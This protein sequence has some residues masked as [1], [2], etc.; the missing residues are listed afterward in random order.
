MATPSTMPGTADVERLTRELADL[1]R[2]AE[3]APQGGGDG[4]ADGGDAFAARMRAALPALL[5]VCLQGRGEGGRREE[6]WREGRAEEAAWPQ[7]GTRRARCGRRPTHSSSLLFSPGVGDR[8]VGVAIRLVDLALKYYPHAVAGAP[9]ARRAGAA[10]AARLLALAASPAAAAPGAADAVAAAAADLVCLAVDRDEAGFGGLVAGVGAAAAGAGRSLAAAAR[11]GRPPPLPL[12]ADATAPDAPLVLICDGVPA[13]ARLAAVALRVVAAAAR[14]APAAARRALPRDAPEVAGRL[15]A[16]AS[17]ALASTGDADASLLAAAAADA[18]RAL[19]AAAPDADPPPP[20]LADGSLAA[21]ACGD[22][23]VV[24]AGARLLADLVARGGA[25]AAAA[26]ARAA[27][28]LPAA[29]LAAPSASPARAAVLAAMAAVAPWAPA[30]PADAAALAPLDAGAAG[31]AALAAVLSAAAPDAVALDAVLDAGS[32]PTSKKRR[33]ASFDGAPASERAGGAPLAPLAALFAALPPTAPSPLS[34]DD[35]L[36]ALAVLARGVGGAAPGARAALGRAA[37]AHAAA[38]VGGDAAPAAPHPSY[39]TLALTVAAVDAVLAACLHIAPPPGRPPVP[40]SPAAA[41]ARDG[42]RALGLPR[43][44]LRALCAAPWTHLDAAAPPPAALEAAAKGAALRV[45]AVASLLDAGGDRG[46]PL[47]RG[48]A[49]D[50]GA[51]DGDAGV[52]AAAAAAAAA[53]GAGAKGGAKGAAAAAALLAALATDPDER[54][55]VA[56]VVGARDLARRP[57]GGVAPGSARAAALAARAAAAVEGALPASPLARQ[58][59]DRGCVILEDVTDDSATSAEASAPPYPADAVAAVAAAAAAPR[60]PP[61]LAAAGVDAALAWIAACPE[62]GVDET[63]LRSLATAALDAGANGGAAARA[64]LAASAPALAAPH[65]LTALYPATPPTA[66]A[67]PASARRPELRL[68]HD[69]NGR[70]DAAGDRCARPGLLAALAGAAAALPAPS[71]D[72]LARVIV[73]SRLD[74][75]DPA[76]RAAAGTALAALARARGARAPRAWLLASP[77]HLEYVTRSLT[78]KPGLLAA[79]ADAVGVG[80]ADLAAGLLPSALPAVLEARDG[81]A[82]GALAARLGATPA[83]LLADHGHL[84]IAKVLHEGTPDFEAF[85]RF[86]EDAASSG[87]GGGAAPSAPP[88]D[89]FAFLARAAPRVVAELLAR[90]GASPAWGEPPADAPPGAAARLRSVLAELARL[91]D[92]PPPADPGT[93]PFLGAGDYVTRTLKAYGDALE[94][95]GGSGSG[96]NGGARPAA[97]ALPPL[98]VVR[99]VQLLVDLLGPA[100]GRHAPQLLVLLAAGVRGARAARDDPAALQSLA[101]WRVLVAALAAHAPAQLAAAASQVAVALLDPATGDGPVADAAAAALAELVLRGGLDASTLASLP[102]LPASATRLAPVAA[103]LAAARGDG[104]ADARARALLAPLASPSAAVRAAAAAELNHLL[105]HSRAWLGGL[106]A[107]VADGRAAGRG[108]AA[109]AGPRG[110]AGGGERLLADLVAG[111]LAAC[112]PGAE[113][114]AGA[115]AALAAAECLGVIGAVDPALLAGARLP[116]AGGAAADAAAAAAAAAG[117]RGDL[118]ARLLTEHLLRLLRV[119]DSMQTLDAATF[120]TQE[121]LRAYGAGASGATTNALLDALPPPDRVVA[122]PFLHS[123]YA[124]VL[125]GAPAAG[126]AVF[127]ALPAGAPAWRWLAAWL[128]QLVASHAGGPWKPLYDACVPVF[129]RDVPTC[130]FL[131]PHVVADA[132]AHGGVSARGDVVAEVAAVLAGGRASREGELCVQYTFALLDTLTAWAAAAPPGGGAASGGGGRAAGDASPSPTPGPSGRV[133]GPALAAALDA[134][135]LNLLAAAAAAAG[136]HARAARYAETAAR[137]A[138]GGGLNPAAGKS[139]VYDDGT[140]AGLQAVHGRLGDADTLAGLASLRSG[141]GSPADERL[142]AEAS[143]AW[144]DALALYEVELGTVA[145]GGGGG[146]RGTQPAPRRGSA[147]APTPLDAAT[148]D[149]DPLSTARRGH[150]RCLLG[151]GHLEAA[152]AGVAGWATGGR[153]RGGGGRALH[154]VGVAA[155]WRLGRWDVLDDHLAAATGCAGPGAP[156]APAALASLADGERWEARLGATLAALHARDAPA[157]HAALAA[158]RADTVPALRAAALESYERAAG[159]CVRL[160]VL[161]EVA[162]AGA[163]LAGGAAA[164]AGPL[165]RARRLRWDERLAAVQPSLAA[166]EPILAARRALA[167]LAG[168]RADAGASWLALARLCRAQGHLEAASVASLEAVARG[169]AGAGLERARLLWARDAP[170]TALAT[171][172]AAVAAAETSHVS[173]AGGASP[174]TAADRLGE[175]EATLQLAEWVAAR[176]ARA[177]RDVSS[178]YESA[179]ALAPAA[180]S[181]AGEAHFSYGAYLD[182]LAADAQARQAGAAGVAASRGDRRGDRLGGRSRIPLG[183]EAPHAEIVPL[184]LAHYGAAL[185]AGSARAAQALPRLLTVFFEHGTACVRAPR[186]ANARERKAREA[187]LD[188]MAKLAARAPLAVWLPALPQLTSRLC[189]AHA[190]TRGVTRALLVRIA[191]AHP[192]QALWALASVSRSAHPARAEAAQG[193]LASARRAADGDGGNAARSL[194]AAFGS[195]ADHL[196]RLCHFAPAGRA[197]SFSIARDFPGLSRLLPVPVVVPVAACLDAAPPAGAADGLVS[198]AGVDDGVAVLASLQRPKKVTLLGSDGAAYA[199][200]AKPKDDLRKDARM[201]EVAGTANALFARAAPARARGLR[202]RRFA[203]Q[204]LTEDCGLVEWVPHTTVY[205]TCC[206]EVY[207]AAGLYDRSRTNAEVKAAYDAAAG[208]PPT[209]WLARMLAKFPPVLHAWLLDRFPDPGAWHGARL[210]FARGA[211]AWSIL[212]HV[213]GLGDRH[214]ENILLD[215]ATGDVVHVDFS[216]LFDRGLTLEKPEVVPFRLTQNVVDACGVAGVE[217]AFRAAAETTLAVLRGGGGTLASVLETFLHDPLVEWSRGGG[218]GGGGGG[219]PARAPAATT[220]TDSDGGN[221]QAQDALDTIRG[222]L[223]GTLLGVRSTPTL[224]LSVEGHVAAL[225]EEATDKRNLA[226]MYIWWQAYM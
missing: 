194:H 146:G 65:V 94:G 22:A 110:G 59:L 178:L 153:A 2:A 77:R 185:G 57:P 19:A 170:A 109:G 157:F 190:E 169:A 68:L 58:W 159:A 217:G 171:L 69:L 131:L 18:G 121:V 31:A 53:L 52:R 66:D 212:G 209:E 67:P 215:A 84:A 135:D 179:I 221:P 218:G 33:V 8:E 92:V 63:V 139:A 39:A 201:M 122:A 127:S 117:D 85:T 106:L 156:P 70:L 36:R 193:V 61:A 164:A 103:A 155:A 160:H 10:L 107:S 220:A 97:S 6:G 7:T 98:V 5:D 71:P 89:F 21:I 224:P 26:A 24:A 82:L 120:A 15:L 136:A 214:G 4:G 90:A 196:V 41:T 162:D 222:R 202:L 191:A 119:A 137:R 35:R 16:T 50:R 20:A 76:V 144:G 116:G 133:D 51:H 161:Q 34:I 62:G 23:S 60:A 80:E 141:G 128:R 54:A 78:S 134:V 124:L 79:L 216:C 154:A 168:A 3:A 187:A 81:R 47:A 219:G 207:A 105:A 56:A 150:L 129:R 91:A 1:I 200:L 25:E 177:A 9:P 126:A 206:Q 174:A 152:L 45:A 12:L 73:T 226:A 88:A 225:I 40:A 30:A 172:R 49:V 44:A 93:A 211:A 151:M 132:L 83:S 29:A 38:A 140:V 208:R 28:L 165:D 46:A 142:A 188:A 72:L 96:G 158:A 143:G 138:F 95:A 180:S 192:H 195:L 148:E 42:A 130:L 43:D 199:F 17:H 181:V 115:R 176:G 186:P 175:A 113:S 114:A 55:A 111:L 166:Q 189:H 204:P 147:L 102:P 64:A 112:A 198:V 145:E 37:A 104:S 87:G 11:G 183:E 173:R 101:A 203:V 223:G 100:V 118:P 123:H 32:S 182:A 75:S 205:R 163:L 108:G 167:E 197:R 149:D 48:S 210:A 99:C 213:V 27:P 14:A 125:A 13:A 74:D 184:V 86:F